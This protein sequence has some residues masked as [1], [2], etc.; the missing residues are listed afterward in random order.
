[1][2]PGLPVCYALDCHTSGER[3]AVSEVGHQF[4]EIQCKKCQEELIRLKTPEADRAYCPSCYPC[5]DYERD[6]HGAGLIGGAFVDE[7]T[8]DRIDRLRRAGRHQ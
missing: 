7:H 8:R 4:L 2:A 1:M 3:I 5:N 6:K